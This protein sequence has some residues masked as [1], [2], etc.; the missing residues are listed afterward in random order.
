MAQPPTIRTFQVF[1]DVPP[2]LEPLLEVAHNL[3]WVWNPDAMEL[4]RR[5][6]RDLWEAVYHN[7]VKML[8]SISQ[9]KLAEA[10]RDDGYLAHLNRVNAA[11]KEHMNQPGWYQEAHGDKPK[12]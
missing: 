7:P 9:Q 10:A 11:F 2:A 5:L 4:F 8:G 12:L 3:W 6:D 1:P